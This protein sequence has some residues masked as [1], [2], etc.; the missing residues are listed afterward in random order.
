[1][2]QTLILAK[3]G[4]NMQTKSDNLPKNFCYLSMQ[5]YSTH[6]HERTRPCCFSRIETNSYMPGVDVDSVL[7]GKNTTTGIVVTLVIL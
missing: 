7:I 3:Q 4:Q 2:Q 5:G 6:S 1:V